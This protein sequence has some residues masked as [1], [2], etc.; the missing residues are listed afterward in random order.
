MA[1]W[2]AVL[3]DNCERGR[4]GIHLPLRAGTIRPSG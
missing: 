4:R 1:V 2:L 3:G